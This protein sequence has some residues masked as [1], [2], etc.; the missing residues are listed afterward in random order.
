[1]P[2][3][4]ISGASLH[5]TTRGIVRFRRG[6]PA[7]AD[8]LSAFARRVFDETFGPDN[9]PRDM[10]LYA[11]NAFA[12]SVQHGELTD[13]ARVCLI[14]ESDGAIVAYALLHVGSTDP[15]VNGPQPVEIERFYVDAP[16]HGAGVADAM[17]DRVTSGAREAGGE[18][19]WLGVWDRNARAIRFYARRGFRDA[20]AHGFLLGTDLQ[21]DRIM[22]HSLAAAPAATPGRDIAT[23]RA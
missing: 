17:M 14:G 23:W 8:A 4:N 2:H 3:S 20:G 16:W 1:M 5:D 11:E 12:P 21:T 15:A 22:V 6:L 7:D 9:D 13:L 19:L 10:G 18:T